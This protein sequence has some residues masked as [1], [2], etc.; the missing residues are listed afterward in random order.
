MIHPTLDPG[1]WKTPDSQVIIVDGQD[2]SL[3]V[4]HDRLEIVDGTRETPRIR[5]LPRIPRQAERIM[6]L[7]HHGYVTLDALRWLAGAGIGVTHMAEDITVTSG[8]SSEDAALVRSQVAGCLPAARYLVVTKMFGQAV[9][10]EQL[11]AGPAA[12]W[13]RETARMIRDAPQVISVDLLRGYE[14]RV[15]T[16]HWKAWAAAAVNWS[17]DDLARVPAHWRAWNGRP[18]LLHETYE[19]NC[20][21]T[22]P[23]NAALNYCYRVLESEALHTC[24]AYGFHPDLGIIHATGQGRRPFVLDL[25]EP[26]RPFCDRLIL[27]EIGKQYFNRQWCHEIRNGVVVLDPPLTHTIAGWAL[28]MRSELEKAASHLRVLLR[29]PVPPGESIAVARSKS[30]RTKGRQA[31]KG[32]GQDVLLSPRQPKPSSDGKSVE[33]P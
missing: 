22:D 20:H 10:L 8:P 11:G 5:R 17:P 12:Q 3:T 4:R 1:Q 6:I 24:Y 32:Y 25:M 26:I 30:G 19:R 15:A 14:G 18:S 31:S 29:K 28:D 13:V 23:I 9:T 33:A 21:A 27:A 16:A 2:V 7:G